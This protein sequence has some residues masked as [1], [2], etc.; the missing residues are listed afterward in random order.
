MEIEQSEECLMEAAE[1][2][3]KHCTDA[4]GDHLEGLC[5]SELSRFLC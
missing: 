3:G 4:T 1:R 5:L 2:R